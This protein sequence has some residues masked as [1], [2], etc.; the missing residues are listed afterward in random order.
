M[1]LVHASKKGKRQRLNCSLTHCNQEQFCGEKAINILI[2]MVLP[3]SN[4]CTMV[5]THVLGRKLVF[6]FLFSFYYQ[7]QCSCMSFSSSAQKFNSGQFIEGIRK[8]CFIAVY[9]CLSLPRVIDLP[10]RKQR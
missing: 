6:F 2:R 5:E 1:S 4:A 10:F 7:L 3:K 9:L 8:K